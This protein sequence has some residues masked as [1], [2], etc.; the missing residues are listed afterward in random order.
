MRR[1]VVV[2]VFTPFLAATAARLPF[3]VVT[4]FVFAFVG[5]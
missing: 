1:S 4:T 2:V 5:S 3:V